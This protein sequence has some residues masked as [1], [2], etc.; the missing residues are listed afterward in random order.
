MATVES[1]VIVE[2]E[3]LNVFSVHPGL[4]TV[5]RSTLSRVIWEEKNL[6]PM[7]LGEFEATL[8]AYL[9]L[10][11]GLFIEGKRTNGGVTFLPRT[12]PEQLQE[13]QPRIDRSAPLLSKPFLPLSPIRP[14]LS[15]KS[16]SSLGISPWNKPTLSCRRLSNLLDN[17]SAVIILP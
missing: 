17:P 10:R 8:K 15:K 6:G 1:L 11:T 3:V 14:S 5:S 12:S 9:S 2:R 4:V 13:L 7:N 16:C